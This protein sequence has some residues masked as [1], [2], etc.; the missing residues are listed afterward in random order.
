[1][2]V[3]DNPVNAKFLET[4]LKKEGFNPIVARSG[5]EA[6]KTLGSGGEFDLIITDYSMPEMT[7][8][9][10]IAQLNDRPGLADI[11]LILMSSYTDQSL[12]AQ[13][14]ELG[15]VDFLVKPI[16]TKV[17]ANKVKLLLK[18]RPLLIVPR[19][20][21]MEKYGLKP[22]E[23]DEMLSVFVDQIGKALPS[24]TEIKP[25]KESV[26]E[27]ILR[28]MQELVESGRI[29]GTEKLTHLY[30]SLAQPFNGADCRA[31]LASLQQ[32]AEFLKKRL[33]ISKTA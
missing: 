16:N 21:T 12:I 14:R 22:E 27:P 18:D 24:I 29:I 17:L 25:S 31:L 23:Y 13:G 19:Q 8:I 6:L 26:Q 11:P 20:R 10:F 15:C 3:E 7:G 5:E 33:P 9:Q 30:D 1:M 32:V 4:I 28:L 2:I